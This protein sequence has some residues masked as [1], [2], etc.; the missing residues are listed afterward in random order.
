MDSSKS[1]IHK[2]LSGG[3]HQTGGR[4]QSITAQ[5]T[6]SARRLSAVVAPQFTKLDPFPLLQK[7]HSL[8]IRIADITQL[9]AAL[10]RYLANNAVQFNPIDFEI[11]DE[12]DSRILNVSLHPEEMVL[13][14]GA[15]RIFSLTFAESSSDDNG[16]LI[17]KIRHPV[18]G[19]RV[20]EFIEQHS[21]D[22]IQISSCVDDYDRCY[23]E[24]FTSSW[25]GA[26]SLCGCLFTKVQ[27]H[28]KK[29]E[30]LLAVVRP[31]FA[32]FDENSIRSIKCLSKNDQ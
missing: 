7:Y 20:F 9:E 8:R 2:T 29:D 12:N 22:T 19:M 17:S 28:F 1:R 26:L 21:S 30:T 11:T 6:R 16:T 15:R 23:I 31:Q 25:L 24:Q 27:W 18:S 3:V 13:A 14:E 32:F 10:E 5:L 4:K